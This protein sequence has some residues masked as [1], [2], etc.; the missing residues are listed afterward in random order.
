SFGRCETDAR[1]LSFKTRLRSELRDMV[2]THG[3]RRFLVTL[4]RGPGTW[5]AEMVLELKKETDLTLE[6][7]IPYEELAASWPKGDRDR[8]FRIAEQ[9]DGETMFQTRYTAD[10]RSKCMRAM[11]DRSD[12]ALAV[13]AGDDPALSHALDYARSRGRWVH[14]LQSGQVPL[15]IL[16]Q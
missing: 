8:Y 4:E 11:I 9:A 10:C 6:C 13:C 1:C 15:E 2:H 16:P 3:V 7:V 14:I 5:A 12:C